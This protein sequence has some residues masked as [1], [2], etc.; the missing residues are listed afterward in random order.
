MIRDLFW[1]NVRFDIVFIGVFGD[2]EK[3][4]FVFSFIFKDIGFLF[5]LGYSEC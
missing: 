3:R 1:R 5:C 2:I 4:F